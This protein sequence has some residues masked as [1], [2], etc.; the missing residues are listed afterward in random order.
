MGKN[1]DFHNLQTTKLGDIGEEL[2]DN[3]LYLEGFDG[4]GTSD[5][6]KVS[7]EKSHIIDRV[8]FT[9]GSMIAF[10]VKTKSSRD[11]YPDISIDTPDY[12][13][14]KK[15]AENG[16]YVMVFFVDYKLKKCYGGFLSG[17]RIERGIDSEC[18][19]NG[20]RYPYHVDSFG[21][22]VTY[23]PLQNMTD[24]F[25]LTDNDIERLKPFIGGNK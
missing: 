10:D 20:V 22:S 17:I 7:H 11:L 2:V 19:V 15:L 24:Y 4:W 16:N 6:Y 12:K 23:L 9:A 18:Y 8:M 3:F 25:D 21:K 14:Y 13:T 5:I 1:E